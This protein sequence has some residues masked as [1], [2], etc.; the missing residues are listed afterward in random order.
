MRHL[1]VPGQARDL[2]GRLRQRAGRHRRGRIV[3]IPNVD[4]RI[5][6]ARRQQIR[7]RRVKIQSLLEENRRDEMTLHKFFFS[8][9]RSSH[10]LIIYTCVKND[11]KF[12]MEPW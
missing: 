6:G 8:R 5:G 7:R 2:V 9:V 12:K 3:Q 10:L 1:A 4:L 11:D